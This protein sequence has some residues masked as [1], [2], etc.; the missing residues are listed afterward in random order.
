MLV[1]EPDRYA[2]GAFS[3]FDN[4]PFSAYL[5]SIKQLL[6]YKYLSYG[7]NPS[8]GLTRRTLLHLLLRRI[9]F[10]THETKNGRRKLIFPRPRLVSVIALIESIQHANAKK[11]REALQRFDED[12]ANAVS[13]D[14]STYVGEV[15]S[16]VA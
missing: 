3:R 13:K 9:Y 5:A 14:M 12:L 7:Y 6:A 15:M 16:S 8:R 10:S 4:K 1:G 2:A 11:R